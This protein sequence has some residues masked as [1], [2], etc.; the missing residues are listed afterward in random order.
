MPS[1]P[2]LLRR[3]LP[4][5]LVLTVLASTVAAAHPYIR[6]GEAPVDSLASLTLDLAHGCQADGVGHAE[7]EGEGLG[8]PTTEVAL[9][10]PAQMRIVDVPE[11][12][13]WEVELEHD[14]DGNVEVVSWTATTAQQPA[15]RLP[16]D[17]VID[18]EPGDELHLG[19]F[20][21]C[22]ELTHRWVGTPEEPAEDPAV[23]L[24]L[25]EADPDRPD[26]DL[27]DE[28]PE[29]TEEDPTVIEDDAAAGT[30]DEAAA[31][32]A[33]DEP[34]ADETAEAPDAEQARVTPPVEPERSPLLWA[35]VALVGAALVIAILLALRRRAPA[36]PAPD[37]GPEEGSG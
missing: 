32:D 17:V 29:A 18:G 22:D 14:V 1:L 20:Q 15:P 7:G 30:A 24:T 34:V 23:R 5:A 33:V 9:E 19:V 8:A 6:E 16:L 37:A 27:A 10:V 25:V 21:A 31:E 3:A 4:L 12:D 35:V 13:G 36:D 26:P 11:L 2:V 28:E